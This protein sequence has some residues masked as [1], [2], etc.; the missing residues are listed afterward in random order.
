MFSVKNTVF[1]QD[2]EY[3]KLNNIGYKLNW[4]KKAGGNHTWQCNNV[5]EQKK[6]QMAPENSLRAPEKSFNL[7]LKCFK[8]Y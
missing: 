6:E 1:L 8:F 3:V 7:V 2:W 5:L 4:A